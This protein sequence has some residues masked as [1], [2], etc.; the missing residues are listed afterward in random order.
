[1]IR[2][3]L[4]LPIAV[5]G[6]LLWGLR[7]SIAAL[8]AVAAVGCA[9]NHFAIHA[10]C[11]R[12][13]LP[14]RWG[15]FWSERLILWKF[16]LPA[17]LGS[18]VTSPAM[19]VASS[20]LVNQPHGYAEMGIFSAANQWRTAV[21]FLPALLS[22]PLLSMLSNL[23]VGQFRSF[24][25]LLRAN[26]TLSFGLSALIAAPI[27]LCSHWIMKVYGRGFKSGNQVLTLLVVA[28]VISSTAAVVG[29]AIASLDKM[30]WGLVLNSVWAV[31]LLGGSAILV[32]RYGALGL[33]E[34][35]LVSYS[36]HAL[37]SS[38][39]TYLVLFQDPKGHMTQDL[40]LEPS[41]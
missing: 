26:L 29:Q 7:G 8:V 25:K 22:Q 1:L 16:S 24:K 11:R 36:M 40:A 2:G 14:V 18:A 31:V 37:T 9:L 27:V 28:T 39:F 20:L 23:G 34:A 13:G 32:P 3:I 4:A 19:F 5:A 33:A 35:F 17:F 30:W 21:G 12:N 15:S 41:K 10:E 38:L 6:V